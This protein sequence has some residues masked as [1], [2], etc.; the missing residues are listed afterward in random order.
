M[1][2]QA[3]SIFEQKFAQIQKADSSA[4]S[5]IFTFPSRLSF[6]QLSSCSDSGQ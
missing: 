5:S 6:I 3:I 2:V 4:Q 1:A